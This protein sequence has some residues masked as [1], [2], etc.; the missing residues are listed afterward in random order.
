MVYTQ[1][2][3]D[4]LEAA[5]AEG[6]L[7]VVY[8]NKTVTYRSLDD[9]LRIRGIMRDDLGLNDGGNGGNIYPRHSR[10]FGKPQ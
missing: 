9:M 7:M 2:Q 10:G 4:A 1:Q 6:V 3:L 5:I 8:G